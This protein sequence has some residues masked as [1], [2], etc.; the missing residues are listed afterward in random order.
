[1]SPARFALLNPTDID[2]RCEQL[3]KKCKWIVRYRHFHGAWQRIL[4]ES[5]GNFIAE[6]LAMVTPLARAKVKRGV[7]VKLIWKHREQR[8]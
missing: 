6:R 1:M 7:E 4:V 2:G 5:H 3:V 8:G